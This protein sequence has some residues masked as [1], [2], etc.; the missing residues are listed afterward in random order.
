MK[1][2]KYIKDNIILDV[3]G[4]SYEVY[5]NAIDKVLIDKLDEGVFDSIKNL[6]ITGSLIKVFKE[7][8]SSIVDISKQFDIGL[9]DIVIAFKQRDI[10]GLLRSVGFKIKLLFKSI[11]ALST[12]V[13]GG[14]FS[15]FKEI[16]DSGI[17]QKIR[18]G[19]MKIDDVLNQY[20][21]L[22]KIGG[23]V[24]AGLLLYM[25]LN[26]TFIGDLDY[27]FNF[28]DIAAAL[29]GSFSL[30]D[31]FTSP[32]G[33]MLITLFGTGSLLGLSVPWLGKSLYNFTVAIVYT[34]FIKS[35]KA[36]FNLST[37]KSKIKTA[38]LK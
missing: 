23:L 4:V 26:M 1:F 32:S 14:L 28:G 10:F 25:W 7:L 35:K 36:G 30:T 3:S 33:L 19:V 22:K 27:D 31:L 13:R 37:I 5:C 18:S 6:K 16:A 12:A 38:R 17:M 15:I 24:I 2:K 34:G 21:K 29:K 8:K 11:N 9:S 20:P